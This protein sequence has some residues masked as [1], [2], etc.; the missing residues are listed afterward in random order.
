MTEEEQPVLEE[1]PSGSAEVFERTIEKYLT[2]ANVNA[3]FARPVRQGDTVVIPAAEVICGFGF[4]YGEA[5][6]ARAE[7]KG[8][9]SGGG[10]GG[11]V[12]S[13]PVAVIICTQDG[14]SVQPIIDRSKLWMA[15]LTAVGFM[16]FTLGRMRRPSRH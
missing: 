1:K 8:G 14:V 10:G 4:G 9:G 13:R 15:A 3:V 11:Q 6:G 12:F 2:T 7:D 5:S 16:L